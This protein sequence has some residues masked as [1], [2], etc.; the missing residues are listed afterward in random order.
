[1]IEIDGSYGEGGGQMM[2]S[3]I[4]L[5]LLTGQPFRMT[6]I[7]AG[8][9]KPGLKNQHLTALRTAARIWSSGMTDVQL[10]S[11]SVDF[12]P[13]KL[14]AGVYEIDIGTA[15]SITLLLQTLLPV[16]AFAPGVIELQIKGGTDVQNSP[17]W[18]YLEHVVVPHVAPFFHRLNLECRQRGYYPRGGGI[19]SLYAVPKFESIE[20]ARELGPIDLTETGE[21]TSIEIRSVAS[22]VLAK[23][24]V[25]GRQ[26]Y[27]ATGQLR[28]HARPQSQYVDSLSPGTSVT[29]LGRLSSGAV[30]AADAVGAKEKRAEQVG[31]EAA[32]KLLAELEHGAPVD[33]HLA[34]HLIPW[35]AFRGGRFRATVLSPHTTTH[36]WVV[37]K[38]LGP[39]FAVDE[40]TRTVSTLK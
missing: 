8:R 19:V 39:T 36:I 29:L 12:F 21:L 23:A 9:E 6:N 35:L 24:D 26:V 11:M 1:M 33:E 22:R 38:F 37:E 30:I 25:A 34:D 18:D 17:T 20:A 13:G 10:G 7:R 15:G 31:Q 2:R 27:G 3:A 28:A 32:D 5:S 14:A 4:A 40:T 16:C